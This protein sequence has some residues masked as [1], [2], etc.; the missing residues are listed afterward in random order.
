MK[1]QKRL[2]VEIWEGPTH[3]KESFLEK[4]EF[5]MACWFKLMFLVLGRLGPALLRLGRSCLK[6][7]RTKPKDPRLSM[8]PKTTLI[9]IR[10]YECVCMC[11]NM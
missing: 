7:Y 5:C 6:Q 10:Q 4:E 8:K 11:T 2:Y 3:N 1:G 9:T